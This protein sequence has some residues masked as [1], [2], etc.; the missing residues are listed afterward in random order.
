VTTIDVRLTKDHLALLHRMGTLRA[1]IRV[2]THREVQR[3][4]ILLHA[5]AGRRVGAQPGSPPRSRVGDAP[6]HPVG[7]PPNAA[8]RYR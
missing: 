8:V 5:P 1:T 6:Q 3:R 4:R 2:A 7:S